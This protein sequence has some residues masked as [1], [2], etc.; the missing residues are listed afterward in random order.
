MG[1]ERTCCQP[2]GLLEPAVNAESSAGRRSPLVSAVVLSWNRRDETL[3]CLASLKRQTYAPMEIV[4]L[5]NGST[6][7]SADAIA[8]AFP[9]LA[10][11]RMPKNYGDWQGRDIAAANCRG[12]YLLEVDSDAELEVDTVA[13]LVARM[14]REPEV[15]V[16][17]PRIIDTQSETPYDRG[18]GR[19][20]ADIEHY[21]AVFHGC[22]A[23]IRLSAYREVGGFPH[24]L[25]GGGEPFLSF[26]LLDRGHRI[27]YY[28]E[29]T[30]RHAMSPL[31]RIPRKRYF[32]QNT[33]RLRAVMANYPGF[34]R[35]LL[36]LCW[37]L[38]YYAY[39]AVRQGYLLQLPGDL[40][41]QAGLGVSAWL[42]RPKI[43]RETV[44]LIDYLHCN[45]VTSL[46]D[47][48]AIDRRRS[49]LLSLAK[50][51]WRRARSNV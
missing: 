22:V 11:L 48:R 26:R 17:Q 32:L 40:L 33:Q 4:V 16:V 39:G 6:D 25:L 8:Q 35:P 41:R 27:V 50:R 15:A 28:P 3:Q 12:Q 51:R 36:E 2:D 18:F 14:E 37:K 47:Y 7:D 44:H 13:K 9:E 23:L 49:Y 31:Q 21:Q 43:Q 24:Y 34:G 42:G 5:D 30:V 45:M 20:R 19:D 10:L 46:D 29:T 38:S 1:N